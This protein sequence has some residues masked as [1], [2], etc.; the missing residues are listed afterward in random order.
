MGNTI[1]D[2]GGIDRIFDVRS[3]SIFTVS[4]LTIQGGNASGGG[5]IN[6]DSGTNLTLS[7]VIVTGNTTSDDGGG[8]YNGGTLTLRDTAISS[9]SAVWGGAIYNTN[10]MILDRVTIDA[11]MSS[12]NGG[13]LYNFGGNSVS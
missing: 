12:N 4:G 13:G 11:N 2:A 7:N 9:N 3:S 1:I 10:T 8:I 5:G 6:V